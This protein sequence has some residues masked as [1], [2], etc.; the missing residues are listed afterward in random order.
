[1]SLVLLSNDNSTVEFEGGGIAQ[2]NSWTNVLQTPMVIPK[3]AEVALQSLRVNKAATT[4]IDFSN[5]RFYTYIGQGRSSTGF[6]EPSKDTRMVAPAQ[7]VQGDY[8]AQS[9]VDKSL[10]P[11]LR[12][13]VFHPD[14]QDRINASVQ[15]T[16]TGDF[17]GYNIKFG[18]GDT[19]P[20][21]VFPADDEFV[22]AG[23]QYGQLTDDFTWTNSNKR[24]TKGTDPLKR[25]YGIATRYPMSVRQAKHVANFANAG[26]TAWAIGLSRYADAR[27]E[28]VP[29]TGEGFF[30]I[31]SWAEEVEGDWYDF[32]VIR[33]ADDKL[34]IYHAVVNDNDDRKLRPEE[35]AYYGY[36]GAEYTEP[37]D[38]ATNASGF[39]EVEF[40]LD[41]EQ[42]NVYLSKDGAA[43]TLICSPDLGT[44][45]KENYLKPINIS[46][47]YLYPKYEVVDD[48][49]YITMVHHEGVDVQN[50]QYDGV[51]IL[52]NDKLTF[53]D[54][55][56]TARVGPFYE[57]S[58][59]VENIRSQCRAADLFGVY[60]N[61]DDGFDTEHTFQKYSVSLPKIAL[62][63][64]PDPTY[65]KPSNRANAANVLG[66]EGETVVDNPTQTSGFKTFT[67]HEVPK[68][69]VKNSMFVR[70]TSLTQ[71][72][73][74]G[75]TGNDSK[76]LYHCPRFDSAGRDSGELYYEPAE[77]TYLDISN[78]SDIQ[79]NSFSVDFVTRDEVL[80]NGMMG[81]STVMLHIR[82][83]K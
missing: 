76:I 24:F 80:I 61:F 72:S 13:A 82:E 12:E 16:A 23:Y 2:A 74:N 83:K 38:L 59:R 62:I 33:D 60:N 32:G 41:G 28:I 30:S 20:S 51:D 27:D 36:T 79:V 8:T 65:Y 40:F 6:D 4:A 57:T 3:N 58:N 7:L 48:G 19:P 54:Y 66:F 35:V 11:A 18:E 29:G 37:Y 63:V 45:E 14:Y 17:E 31:P 1:M 43:R 70:L 44:P 47:Q 15:E 68:N 67:S 10:L 69:L 9:F 26:T 52:N 75:Y 55:Y 46:C 5:S 78:P 34:R 42:V 50:F 22:V 53:Q 73:S 71:K 25:G 39:N 77:K 21:D 56:A 81:N 64:A 49:A